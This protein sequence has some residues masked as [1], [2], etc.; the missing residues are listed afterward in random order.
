MLYI[1]VRGV[2]DVDLAV[3]IVIRGAVYVKYEYVVM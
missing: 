3:C 1:C 2:M